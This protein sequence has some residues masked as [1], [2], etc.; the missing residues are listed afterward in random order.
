MKKINA[1]IFRNIFANLVIVFVF[2][3]LSILTYMGGETSVFSSNSNDAYYH[4]NLQSRNVSLMFNVYMGTEFIDG[5]LHELENG[6]VKATFFVG[7]SWANK[8]SDTLQKIISAG[9]EVGNHGYW[10]KDHKNISYE[11]NFSEMELT[12]KV[13]KNLY[14]YDITLFAPPSG[15]YSNT[16]LKVAQSLGYKTIMW[17]KDTIDWRDKDS[18]LIY[19]RAIKNPKGGDLILMHPTEMTLKSLNKI[20]EFYSKNNF[21]LTTVSQNII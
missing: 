16:T 6:N 3:F 1:N 17:T 13:V 7:G 15:S 12:H 21:T 5:I 18:N 10:H 19:N 4:G 14:S 20:I 9:H 2:C 8:N 11:K